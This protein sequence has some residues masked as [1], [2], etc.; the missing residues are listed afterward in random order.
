MFAELGQTD[1]EF[2]YEPF[3]VFQ[4]YRHV[5][6][7]FPVAKHAETVLVVDIGGGTFNSCIIR[8]TEHGLLARGGALSVALGLQA[9][10]SGGAQIDK[11]LLKLLVERTRKKGLEWHD[12]PIHRI[13]TTKSPALLRIEEAK[14][15]LSKA[16]SK[17][18]PLRLADDFRTL[19]PPLFPRRYR[20]QN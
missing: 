12:N 18:T 4:Y 16:I 2:F 1:V 8:T 15:K 10:L 3:A 7:L 9:N 11:E 14:I 6:K 5:A 20:A 17:V 13:E 19:P